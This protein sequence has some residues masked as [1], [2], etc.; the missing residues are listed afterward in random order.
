MDVLLASALAYAVTCGYLAIRGVDRAR[1][2]GIVAKGLAGGLLLSASIGVVYFLIVLQKPAQTFAVFSVIALLFVAA[3][4]ARAEILDTITPL[5][6]VLLNIAVNFAPWPGPVPL[7]LGWLTDWIPVPP[8]FVKTALIVLGLY[9]PALLALWMQWRGP[10]GHPWARFALG[11]WVC[12][13]GIASVI[14]PGWA[15]FMDIEAGD[16]RTWIAAALAA[17]FLHHTVMLALNLLSTATGKDDDAARSIA[18][19]VHVDRLPLSWMLGIATAFGVA[20]YVFRRLV[21]AWDFEVTSTIMIAAAL[22]LG[23]VVARRGPTAAAQPAPGLA[24]AGRAGVFLMLG[25]FVAFAFMQ[26]HLPHRDTRAGSATGHHPAP[27]MPPELMLHYKE[28]ELHA[29]LQSLLKR[30]GV[31][32]TLRK[33][34]GKEYVRVEKEHREAAQRVVDEI[35]GPASLGH[36]VQFKEEARER[37]FTAWLERHG[38]G[39]RKV[40]RL[41]E[42]YLQ[43]DDGPHHGWLL[44]AFNDERD[45]KAAGVDYHALYVVLRNP[46][47]L[48]MDGVAAFVTPAHHERF[49]SWLRDQ[50][51]AHRV[52]DRGGVRFV[53]WDPPPAGL[54]QAYIRQA[55]D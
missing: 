19:S 33:I 24:S 30:D 43:W 9:A 40:R 14:G 42:R 10:P 5:G 36:N 17:Y 49:A 46:S 18:R 4:E 2:V 39:W 53:E 35:R 27:R 3:R 20:A 12:W 51:V 8:G 31:P 15:A 50:A 23:F 37:E 32:Y 28:P 48:T 26:V 1:I 7:S 22:W 44:R 41:D 52:V 47:P 45:A 11:A 34:G 21:I 29:E 38:V 13:V 55:R 6:I 16:P 25:V 54:L